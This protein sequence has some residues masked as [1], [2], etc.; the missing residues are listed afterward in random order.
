MVRDWQTRVYLQ[1]KTGG[2]ERPIAEAKSRKNTQKA[3]GTLYT[4]L[5][6]GIINYVKARPLQLVIKHP[7][8]D[9]SICLWSERR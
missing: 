8:Y 5:A 7:R 6:S 9:F 2:R 1:K 4:S 3:F